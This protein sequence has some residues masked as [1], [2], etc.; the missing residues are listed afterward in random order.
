[1]PR[2]LYLMRHAEAASKES[3]Q[4]DRTRELT[5][6]GVKHAL[7]MGVWLAENKTKIDLIVVSS[8]RRAEQTAQLVAEG[9]KLDQPRI[10]A[11]DSLYESSVRH[12]L[13]YV[14]TMEDAYTDVLI[15]AHNP[16]VSYLAE[17]LTKA[18]VSDMPPGT[19]AA[20]R[21]EFNTWKNVS[22]NT[23]TLERLLTPESVVKF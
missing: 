22:E 3:R 10:L 15:V 8:A 1:M 2:I 20:I 9:M 18:D 5:P 17:Y 21:F 16:A 12:L 19:L 14:N 6:A 7:H 4:D 13:E 11:E 23:G